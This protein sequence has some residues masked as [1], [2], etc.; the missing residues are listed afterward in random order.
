MAR[1]NYGWVFLVAHL[2]HIVTLAAAAAI[3]DNQEHIIKRSAEKEK[4]PALSFNQD[5]Q[6]LAD[7]ISDGRA[8]NAQNHLLALGKRGPPLSFNQDLQ[9]IADMLGHDATSARSH[10]LSLG[11]RVGVYEDLDESEMF[12]EDKRGPALSFNQDLH[13]IADMLDQGR[14]SS[15]QN[16]LLALGKRSRPLSFTQDLQSIADMLDTDRASAA[17]VHLHRLGKRGTISINQDLHSI[18]DYVRAGQDA[19]VPRVRAQG[20]LHRLGKRSE[21]VSRSDY[22]TF[23]PLPYA[24]HNPGRMP[25]GWLDYEYQR[26][27]R[28]TSLSVS[29]SLES[30]SEMLNE[31]RQEN[32]RHRLLG[33]GK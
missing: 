17:Q 1:I 12:E 3:R 19:D 15:A 29:L 25:S 22:R 31:Q 9:S 16:Q 11:K 33:I 27:R 2:S 14:L 8:N 24:L 18:A 6:S 20:L 26:Q 5:L 4:R 7:M 10:L 23:A 30:L 13:S 28:G 21:D 32:A